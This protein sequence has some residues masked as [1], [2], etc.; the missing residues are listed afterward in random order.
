MKVIAGI[1][2]FTIFVAESNSLTQISKHY[3]DIIILLSLIIAEL[4]Q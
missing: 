1:G 3:E 4:R 2:N